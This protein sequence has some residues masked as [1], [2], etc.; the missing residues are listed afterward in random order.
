VL[1]PEVDK[2]DEAG[3]ADFVVLVVVGAASV[4]VVGDVISVTATA[5]SCTASMPGTL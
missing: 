2:D 3:V 1:A 5:P 4:G